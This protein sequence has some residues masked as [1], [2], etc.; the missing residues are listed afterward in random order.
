NCNPCKIPVDTESK[1]GSDGDP[2]SDLTLYRSLAG[3][4]QYLTFTR[5]DL[6]YAY[7]NRR[8]AVNTFPFKNFKIKDDITL[9]PAVP[10]IYGPAKY[11]R[12]PPELWDRHQKMFLD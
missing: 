8:G 6:S 3:A 11:I 1:I 7:G 9:L 5:P 10:Y 12:G 2:I 4:L